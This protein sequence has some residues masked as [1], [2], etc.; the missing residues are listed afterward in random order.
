V[1]SEYRLRSPD[2]IELTC[3]RQPGRNGRYPVDAEGRIDLGD[4][5]RPRIEG[6]TPAECVELI[7]DTLH[8]PQGTIEVRVAEYDSR[9]IYLFGKVSG[10]QRSIQYRGPERLSEVLA[11]A[12]GLGT[13]AAPERV[14]LL[15]PGV[16]EGRPPELYHVGGSNGA[17]AASNIIVQPYDEI[18]I[19]E[20]KPSPFA[21]CFL[22]WFKPLRERCNKFAK[23]WAGKPQ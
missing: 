1:N 20:T 19:D 18:Y 7:A 23:Y 6:A 5:G 2:V 4:V 3:A 21:R 12:G 14:Y 11:R 13:G 9:R 16:A 22:P 17:T 15:R 10:K 8:M